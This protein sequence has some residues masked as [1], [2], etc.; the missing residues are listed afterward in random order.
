MRKNNLCGT[1]SLNLSIAALLLN[2]LAAFPVIID[3]IDCGWNNG[4][5][6]EMFYLVVL[7]IQFFASIISTASLVLLGFAISKRDLLFNIIGSSILNALGIIILVGTN[8]I[9]FCF[10]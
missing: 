5:K 1:I 6:L 3:K 2:A 9:F 10:M 4:T 7:A 8:V